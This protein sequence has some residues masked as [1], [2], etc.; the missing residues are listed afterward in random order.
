P[1]NLELALK[2]QRFVGHAVA[3]GDRR[4]FMSA[5][6]TIDAEQVKAL[7]SEVGEPADMAGLTKSDKVR[8]FFQQGVDEV[9]KSLSHVEAIKKF[10][11]LPA[12]LSVDGGE[13]TPTL[14]VKRK[15]VNDKYADVIEG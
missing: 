15:V 11:I 3:I 6:L 4:P 5:L 14:K 12:D 9:N 10:A 1:S 7:A 8:A 13:L 2:Q